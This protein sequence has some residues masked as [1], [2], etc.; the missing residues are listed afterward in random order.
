MNPIQNLVAF[1]RFLPIQSDR[2]DR[3]ID[4][5]DAIIR[6]ARI[7][8]E[9]LQLRLREQIDPTFVYLL[10]PAGTP[11]FCHRAYVKRGETYSVSFDTQVEIPEG[12]WVVTGGPAVVRGVIIGNQWQLTS[13]DF[14]G[15]VC[16]T[17]EKWLPGCKLRVELAA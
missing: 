10:P 1:F 12:V 13:N 5:V 17:V 8:T 15:Q 2:L 14:Q 16:K 9:A 3:A 6:D 11:M 4:K 7:V